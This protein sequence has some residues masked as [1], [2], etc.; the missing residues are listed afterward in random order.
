M[1][2]S[3][4]GQ[5]V[6]GG[7]WIVAVMDT[8]RIWVRAPGGCDLAG[9]SAMW[10]RCSLATR[11]GR[12]HAP[13]RDIPASYLETVLADPASSL[14]AGPGRAGAVV[15]LASLIPGG[16][17][18]AELGVLV[19]DAWQRRGIGRRLVTEL[20]A[21]ASARQ[22]TEVTASVLAQNAG[23]AD[24]LRRVPGEFCLTRCGTTVEVRVAAGVHEVFSVSRNTAAGVLRLLGLWVFR[25]IAT[26]TRSFRGTRSARRR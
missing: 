5:T 7:G 2:W 16:G 15:A 14:V 20:I 25:L 13:V 22:I 26:C 9:I 4:S 23:V 8:G 6:L 24:L 17:G 19:E 1:I 18:S 11:I 3:D 12:F 21:A 10:E